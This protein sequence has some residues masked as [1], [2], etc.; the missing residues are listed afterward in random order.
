MMAFSFKKNKCQSDRLVTKAVI[1]LRS[2][3]ITEEKLWG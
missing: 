2:I 1:K 3:R